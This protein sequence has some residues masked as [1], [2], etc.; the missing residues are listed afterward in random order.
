MKLK[1]PKTKKEHPNNQYIDNKPKNS[2]SQLLL[3]TKKITFF[4]SQN[5]K[6]NYRILSLQMLRIGE[7]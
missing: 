5:S 6:V 2:K 1:F 7:K 3:G 4:C